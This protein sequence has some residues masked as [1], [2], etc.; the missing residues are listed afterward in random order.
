MKSFE[1]RIRRLGIDWYELSWVVYF[2]VG[3]LREP[4]THRRQTDRRGALRFADKWEV[5]MPGEE[6]ERHDRT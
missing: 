1:H 5:E 6:P 3:R 2:N 4:R